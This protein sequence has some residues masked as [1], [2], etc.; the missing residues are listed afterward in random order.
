MIDIDEQ[1]IVY[2]LTIGGLAIT[3]L[4][5]LSSRQKKL[6][7]YINDIRALDDGTISIDWGYHNHA[8][9][10]LSFNKGESCLNVKKGKALLLAEHPPV[11]FA[12]GKHDKV[13]RTI[14]V[15]GTVIEWIIGDTRLQYRVSG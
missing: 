6:T 13:F 10:E 4:L 11:K 1:S 12:K 3:T 14:V 9:D 5:W 15:K 7:P 8:D 2:S